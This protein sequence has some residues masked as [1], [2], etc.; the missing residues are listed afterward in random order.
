MSDKRL[1]IN[2]RCPT[3]GGAMSRIQKTREANPFF[4][5]CSERCKLAD[6]ARWFRGDYFIG[7]DLNSLSPDQQDELPTIPRTAG[8]A[9]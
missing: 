5:F 4:P 9:S 6:L 2:R 3:C 7:Q 1:T 8:D